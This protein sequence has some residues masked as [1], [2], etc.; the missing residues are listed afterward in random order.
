MLND[1]RQQYVV[2]SNDP[3]GDE[4]FGKFLRAVIAF[5]MFLGLVQY[6]H[7]SVVAWY[8]DMMVRLNDTTT[9]LAGVLPF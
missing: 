9:Y 5:V 1:N 8:R 4:G 2:Q 7:E 6:T 3:K